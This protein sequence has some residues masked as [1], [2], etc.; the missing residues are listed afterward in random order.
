MP[1]TQGCRW[2]SA[3]RADSG[4]CA[5]SSWALVLM[6]SYKPGRQLPKQLPAPLGAWGWSRDG[7]KGLCHLFCSWFYLVSDAEWILLESLELLPCL[8]PSAPSKARLQLFPSTVSTPRAAW[9]PALPCCT[10]RAGEASNGGARAQRGCPGAEHRPILLLASPGS[11]GYPR[12]GSSLPILPA[13][14][15]A[16][17]MEMLLSPWKP[18]AL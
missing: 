16:I 18:H 3:L 2:P 10:L 7:G 5:T 17:R 13:A 6:G 4:H 14:S 15:G 12:E 8:S 1:G 9:S 11:S